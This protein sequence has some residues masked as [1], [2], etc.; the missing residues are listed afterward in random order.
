M[1][2]TATVSPEDIV[3]DIKTVLKAVLCPDDVDLLAEISVKYGIS[4]RLRSV[5]S[6]EDDAFTRRLTGLMNAFSFRRVMR[7]MPEGVTDALFVIPDPEAC[8]DTELLKPYGRHEFEEDRRNLAFSIMTDYSGPLLGTTF[9]DDGEPMF[10][11][12]HAEGTDETGCLIF[13]DGCRV[14]ISELHDDG[15]YTIFGPATGSAREKAMSEVAMRLFVFIAA[16]KAR[17]MGSLSASELV[18]LFRPY[19][20]VYDSRFSVSDASGVLEFLSGYLADYRK[21]I[22]GFTLVNDLRERLLDEVFDILRES[23][24]EDG[25]IEYGMDFDE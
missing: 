7:Y 1:T 2:V 6:T 22:H 15:A 18:V 25:R 19:A 8:A 5:V 3:C 13:P 23:L 12:S 10:I 11:R 21:R 16:V 14:G 4:S 20:H 24:A 17:L 9:H